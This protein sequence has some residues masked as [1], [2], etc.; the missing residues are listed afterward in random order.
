ME[1]IEKFIQFFLLVGCGVVFVFAI[2]YIDKKDDAFKAKI[3]DK[4]YFTAGL[5]ILPIIE[6][7]FVLDIVYDF[8]VADLALIP[9]ETIFVIL[10]GI[11]T[12]LMAKTVMRR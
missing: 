5:F 3:T 11:E 4:E 10:I 9:V 2:I 8:L 6:I 7:I 12:Y 1:I